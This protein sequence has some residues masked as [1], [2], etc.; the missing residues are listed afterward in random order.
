[1][2]CS[3]DI[4]P[5]EVPDREYRTKGANSSTHLFSYIHC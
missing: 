1:M 5:N 3:I 2:Y 4:L